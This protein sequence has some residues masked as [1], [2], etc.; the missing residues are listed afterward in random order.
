[1]IG[2]HLTRASG[3]TWGIT[4]A[5]IVDGERVIVIAGGQP[6]AKVMAFDKATG[7]EAWRAL[8]SD[9]EPGYAQPVIVRA[10]GGGSSS[11]GTARFLIRYTS[12]FSFMCTVT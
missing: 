5:P 10:G 3:P 1:M 2:R 8:P 12:F 4:S 7:Q 11:L 9:T 6:D